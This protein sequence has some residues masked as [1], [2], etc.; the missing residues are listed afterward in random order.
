MAAV[1]GSMP[2]GIPPDPI[3]NSH[4]TI[5]TH[6][7]P[8]RLNVINPYTGTPTSITGAEF[9]EFLH[10]GIVR[11]FGGDAVD[12]VLGTRS[13]SIL[14]CHGACRIPN[15]PGYPENS[16]AEQFARAARPY[17]PSLKD[18][19]ASPYEIST[20]PGRHP[21]H[22]YEFELG[23][24]RRVNGQQEM[25]GRYMD[26][27][28]FVSGRYPDNLFG[29]VWD[30]GFNTLSQTYHTPTSQ[31][32]ISWPGEIDLPSDIRQHIH[33]HVQDYLEPPLRRAPVLPP[34]IIP[35]E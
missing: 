12:I 34:P 16:F 11:I 30:A 20:G 26:I 8:G 15:A 23:V 21:E 24:R 2:V 14:S 27:E 35:E 3:Q 4:M 19:V 6:G 33:T 7:L 31:G 29:Q 28:R 1:D 25:L 9:P 17:F 18:V 5:I 10:S 32:V 22:E 13:M